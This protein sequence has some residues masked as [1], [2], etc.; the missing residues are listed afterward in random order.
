MGKGLMEI[1]WVKGSMSWFRIEIGGKNIHIDP[2]YYPK[3]QAHGDETNEKADLILVTH[4]HRDHFQEETLSSLK[5]DGTIIISPSKVAMKLGPSKQVHVAEIGKE[6][7]LGW[8]KVKPV[9]AYNLGLKGHIFHKKGQCVGYL[10]MIDGKTLYHAGDTGL[11]PEMKELGNIDLAL[12][13]IGGTF[14]MDVDEAAEAART[15]GAK[16]VVPMHNL[17]TPA[18]ELRVRLQN[19]PGI[20]V[21]VAEPGKPFDPF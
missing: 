6:Q 17:K 1:T 16:R 13:P 2:S 9:Y 11:I 10:L 20:Q 15:I 7:D 18:D 5:G 19:D 14:T 3:S 4:A 12:L 21:I 8:V